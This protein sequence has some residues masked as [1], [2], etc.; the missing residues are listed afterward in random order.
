MDGAMVLASSMWHMLRESWSG[1]GGATPEMLA[2]QAPRET[3]V[4]G[5]PIEATCVCESHVWTRHVCEGGPPVPPW[6]YGVGQ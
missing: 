4:L 1:L 3:L 5:A 6:S 2:Y